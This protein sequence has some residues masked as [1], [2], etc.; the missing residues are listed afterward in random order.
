[1]ER[2]GDSTQNFERAGVDGKIQVFGDG[3]FEVQSEVSGRYARGCYGCAATIGE[4]LFYHIACVGKCLMLTSS[5]FIS[6]LLCN[7]IVAVPALYGVVVIVL[8]C[9]PSYCADRSA[10][11]AAQ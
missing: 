9:E 1:M 6:P 8:E 7:L 10:A 3:C 4:E 11:D 2:R 5:I